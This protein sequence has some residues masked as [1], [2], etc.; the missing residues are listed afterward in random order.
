MILLIYQNKPQGFGLDYYKIAKCQF[1]LGLP[2]STSILL[3][4][5]IS[6]DSAE[7]LEAEHYLQAFQIAFDLVDKENQT[8]TSKVI[9]HLNERQEACTQKTRLAQLLKILK[10]EIKDRLY[11]Q[12]LKKN[13]HT[14][15]LLISKIK[16]SIGNRNSMLHSAT[17][18]CNGIMN[19]YTTNDAFL[20]DNLSWASGAT[21][22]NRFMVVSSLGMIHM[23]NKN[24]AEEILNPYFSGVANPDQQNSPYSTAGAYY[25]YGLIH[26]N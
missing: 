26:S 25:A 2:E 13:N 15:M 7:Y 22:W 21:N 19:A 23:G 6:N 12:F 3:E 4:K 20:R 8:Y 16:D 18:W 24:Q 17:V 9:Q 11:L 5:L 1:H 10:G 14:D